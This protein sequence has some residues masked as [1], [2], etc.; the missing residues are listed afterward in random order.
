MAHKLFLSTA[1]I[2]IAAF[3]CTLAAAAEA[4]TKKFPF[5]P[6]MLST[7]TGKPVTPDKFE[8]PEIC[9][10]CHPD[11]HAQWKGSMHSNAFNDPV[12]Q[13]LWKMGEKDTKGFTKNL[14]GGCHTVVGV[15]SGDLTF[16]DNQ[17]VTN[18]I[19]RQGVQCDVCHTIKDS[20]F[21]ETPT[22]E[23]NNASLVVAPGDV[24]RGPY[25][26][27]VSPY[28]KSEYSE[29]HTKS[30]F[31]AN[32]HQ[33][34]HPV[35][36]FHIER[37]YDEWKY[38]VYAQNDIQCQDCHMMPVEKSI[39]V[40]KTMKKPQNP[41]Q[42]STM[43]PKRDN[44][45]TH[46]FVGANFTVPA[47]LGAKGHADMAEKRLKS[48]AELDIIAPKTT[49]PGSMVT[50][51]I[52]V[53]N[54]GAGHN[55]PTSLT[56][57]RQMWLDIKVTDAQG[58]EVFRSGALDEK[59]DL[60]E[61]ARIFCA[62]AVDKDGKHTV[63]PWEI[64]RFEYVKTIPPKGSATETFSFLTPPDA[65]LPLDVRVVLRYRSYPQSVANLLLGKD[66]PVLPI[67]DMVEK[68]IKMAAN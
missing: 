50:M 36:N 68:N 48:A 22:Y 55:L 20:S 67:V 51:G 37:T 17:F 64:V 43:G 24:K 7:D 4:D 10:G 52:K 25:K 9:G 15:V 61:E 6:S 32:C 33:V 16:K 34:F 13:A 11:I 23:P 19:A 57:V 65:K 47:L 42:P 21:L 58:K 31:C 27:S 40:A 1:C 54:V 5:Y 46:E 38:S 66:A 63:K 53:S 28:H 2:A 8:S 56:E 18:E 45:F 14:C 62:Y 12:F 39:E 30:K 60:G 59:G 26:D 49:K 41:G 3:C 44:M 35:S 29:L